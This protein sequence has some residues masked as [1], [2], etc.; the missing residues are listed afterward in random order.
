MHLDGTGLGNFGLGKLEIVLR[1]LATRA[2]KR[3]ESDGSLSAL[4]FRAYWWAE[5]SSAWCF[6]SV[7]LEA[8]RVFG[9]H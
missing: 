5:V 7:V 3:A 6:D 4:A 2:A 9:Q 8:V 1:G